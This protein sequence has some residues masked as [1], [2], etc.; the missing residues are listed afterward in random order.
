MKKRKNKT[1]YRFIKRAFDIFCSFILIVIL[2]LPLFIIGI[3]VVCDSKGGAFFIQKRIG[4][5]GKIFN[6]YKFRS[7]CIN[8]EKNGVY[9]DDKDSRITKVGKF[10]RKTSLD[11]LP[12]LFNILK[13]DMS[14]VGPRPVLTY[15]PWSYDKYSEHQL[16]MFETRPGI[17][18]WAQINGRKTVEWHKR[19]E[20]NVW[21]VEHQSLWL[22]IKI[23]FKTIGKVLGNK[24]NQNI[25]ESLNSEHLKL[26]YITNDPEVASVIEKHGV[27]RIFIDMEYI[28]K[29]E[30]QKGLDSVKNHHTIEDIKN[31]RKAISVAQLL[32]RVNP[33]HDGS[34]NEINSAIDAGADILMLPM[35]KTVKEVETFIRLV[36][37]R[38]KICLLL[39]TKEAVEIIDDIIQLDGIDEIHIGLNDLHLSYGLKFMFELISNGVVE[40][41]CNKFKKKGITFGFGGISKLGVGDVP[42]EYIIAEHYRLGSSMAILSRSFCNCSIEKDISSIE[43]KFKIGIQKIR[44]YEEELKTKNIEFFKENYCVLVEKIDL[45]SRKVVQ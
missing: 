14:F 43:E 21:Y 28:G 33:I 23:L 39:E 31:V 18:G 4:K 6:M 15:H 8:A 5:N 25:G 17:T 27:D 37:K 40:T 38:C 20:M 11:E 32:V 2:A 45:V 22:D 24:D 12:Q 1:F 29:D 30:R 19:I 44:E 35:F 36:D 26:M 3:I 7:M 41:L 9:S 34:E 13:G 42:A 16:I 10:I